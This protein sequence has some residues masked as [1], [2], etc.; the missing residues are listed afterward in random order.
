MDRFNNWSHLC[1]ILCCDI[2]GSHII[3]FVY[4]PGHIEHVLFEIFKVSI[5][6]DMSLTRTLE[7]FPGIGLTWIIFNW[8]NVDNFELD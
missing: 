2:S 5:P 4:V 6:P 1:E 3:N 8:I 7:H